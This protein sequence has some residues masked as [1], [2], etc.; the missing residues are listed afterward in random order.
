MDIYELFH[1]QPTPNYVLE[2]CNLLPSILSSAHHLQG[3]KATIFLILQTESWVNSSVF[4]F[5]ETNIVLMILQ[6]QKVIQEH[7][8]ISFLVILST[9]LCM[10]TF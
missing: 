1:V 9:H 8:I 2:L 3:K 4:N 6:V 7:L 5:M 10:V